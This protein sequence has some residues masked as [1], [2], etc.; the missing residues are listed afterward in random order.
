MRNTIVKTAIAM[1]VLLSGL[2]PATLSKASTE[3]PTQPESSQTELTPV[4][5]IKFPTPRPVESFWD[6]L[7]W[8]ETNGNWKDGGNWA[9]GLGIAQSTWKGYG[10]HQFAKSPARATREEQIIVAHRI[11]VEGWQT[12]SFRTLED[13]NNNKPFFREPVGFGGWGALPCAGGTPKLTAHQPETVVAQK[14]KWG[15]KGRL[16]G[17]LQAVLEV[18]Q[19]F[20]Y[21][22]KTWAAHQRYIIKNGL[23]RNLAPTNPNLKRPSR[24]PKSE[25]KRCV[26]FE[27]MAYEAGFPKNQIVIVSY[28]MWKESRCIATVTN[29]KDPKGGSRGLLQINGF[30]TKRL[31]KANIIRHSDD[32]FD[33]A[34]NL[35]AG[36]YVFTYAVSEARY[37][38][39]W[40]PWSVY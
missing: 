26:E 36:F 27:D 22:P 29:R 5:L 21:G 9:G 2:S 35:R 25:T 28:V 40:S 34:T 32:L 19:D 1:S 33:P 38:Y 6:K 8:C 3:L 30:W 24:I 20:M 16:V 10:G 15:Q 12:K 31:V 23:P 17:D 39:G 14:F 11:A 4:E 7:A 37:N 13:K 18:K